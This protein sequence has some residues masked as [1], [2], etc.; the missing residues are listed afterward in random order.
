VTETEVDNDEKQDQFVFTFHGLDQQTIS[1]DIMRSVHI[2]TL[3]L[4]KCTNFETV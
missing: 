3:F 1:D 2:T 4:K